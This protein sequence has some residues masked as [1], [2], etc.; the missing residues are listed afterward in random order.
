M[1][2]I[3]LLRHG[4][5]LWNKENLFTGWRDVGLSQ[6]GIKEAGEAGKILRRAGFRFDIAYTSLLK[7]AV[8][9]LWICLEEMDQM[10]VEIKPS[11]RLN[12]RHF[13]KFQGKNKEQVRKKYGDEL[14]TEWRRGL[15]KRPPAISRKD[16]DYPG[17]YPK[18]DHLT[19]DQIPL[20]ESLEDTIKRLIPFWEIEISEEIKAGKNVIITAHGNSIKALIMHFSQISKNAV[21]DINIPTGIPLV[22]ELDANF[23]P[24]KSYYLRD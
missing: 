7:R 4:E 3:V 23:V 18:Y 1:Y 19:P 17:N 21:T 13:G 24:E 6:Q 22:Y 16:K 20:T 2:K 9:T 8:K 14:F 5:S 10:Y 15:D 11:W 12:E